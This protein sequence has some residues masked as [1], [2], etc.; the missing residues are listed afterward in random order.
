MDRNHIDKFVSEAPDNN[1]NISI[2]TKIRIIQ[3]Q[4]HTYNTFCRYTEILTEV[5]KILVREDELHVLQFF[6]IYETI[7][8]EEKV[9]R[10]KML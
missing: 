2:F 10:L 6:H 1:N 7:F 9:Q 5:F 3:L 4:I 8:K